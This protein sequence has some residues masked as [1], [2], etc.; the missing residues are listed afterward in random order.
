MH[1]SIFYMFTKKIWVYFFHGWFMVTVSLFFT[2]TLTLLSGCREVG[3]VKN[4]RWSC[5]F[6]SSSPFICCLLGAAS[7][8]GLQSRQVGS[9]L[10]LI[11]HNRPQILPQNDE[12]LPRTTPPGPTELQTLPSAPP[13]SAP[14]PVLLLVSHCGGVRGLMEPWRCWREA[15]HPTRKDNKMWRC[16]DGSTET[17]PSQF[18]ITVAMLFLFK[19]SCFNHGW[20][21]QKLHLCVPA[22]EAYCVKMCI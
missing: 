3:G 4:W 21:L 20:K 11:P 12:E 6:A 17:F 10:T 9:R 2:L 1:Y 18:S 13:T 16:S 7:D 5:I 8:R 15:F 19:L 22:A 14:W